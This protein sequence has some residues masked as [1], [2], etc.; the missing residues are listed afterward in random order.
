MTTV[1]EKPV[2]KPPKPVTSGPVRLITAPGGPTLVQAPTEEAPQETTEFVEIPEPEQPDLLVLEELDE[3]PFEEEKEAPPTPKE[4]RTAKVEPK[5]VQRKGPSKAELEERERRRVA[6]LARKITRDAQLKGSRVQ[7]DYPRSAIR[8]GLE[9]VVVVRVTVG[10]NGRVSSCQ[11]SQSSGH[12]ILDRSAV[13]AAR[14]H[15][16]SPAQN[17]LGQ[18]VSVTKL[19][20]FKFRLTG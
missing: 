2:K 3:H 16:F 20:P 8:K 19:M 11:I 17:G 7:P 13:D 1:L 12:A 15:R 5:P 9:G 10:P 4:T 18:A 6:A 14:R